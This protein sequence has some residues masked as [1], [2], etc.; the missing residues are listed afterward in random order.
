[1]KKINIVKKNTEFSRIIN[2]RKAYSIDVK[3]IE[4]DNKYLMEKYLVDLAKL[5][6]IMKA[7]IK[8]KFF[9][10]IIKLKKV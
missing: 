10:L 6:D 5:K 8:T 9:Y 4:L 2:L 1:M 7:K 3:L